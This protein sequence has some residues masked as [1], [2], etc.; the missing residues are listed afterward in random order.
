MNDM[1]HVYAWRRGPGAQPNPV[2]AA[3]HGRRCRVVCRGTM[4]SILI[5]MDDGQRVVTSRRA[6]RR[7]R[8]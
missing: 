7:I 3:L 4:D 6:V 1:T 5:E 2:R 8:A